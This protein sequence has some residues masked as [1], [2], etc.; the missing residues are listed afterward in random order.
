MTSLLFDINSSSEELSQLL[1]SFDC[2]TLQE[3]GD[4][5]EQFG[6]R[7]AQARAGEREWVRD[8]GNKWGRDSSQE[9][10]KPVGMRGAFGPE[11]GHV[12]YDRGNVYV[13]GAPD[14]EGFLPSRNMKTN[15]A[16]P[17]YLAD[18]LI[19]KYNAVKGRDG[20]MIWQQKQSMAR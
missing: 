3:L 2:A 19:K 8:L 10:Q 11:K 14:A 12:V 17:E 18:V 1:E 5:L 20:R 7:A 13:L 16:G 9:Q 6:E 15:Q 4:L